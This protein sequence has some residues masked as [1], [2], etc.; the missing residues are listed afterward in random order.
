[1][2]LL[3]GADNEQLHKLAHELLPI[4]LKVRRA[5]SAGSSLNLSG[6]IDVDLDDKQIETLYSYLRKAHED[7]FDD[8]SK[9]LS[10]FTRKT[11]YRIF[12]NS[13]WK[14]HGRFYGGFWMSLPERHKTTENGELVITSLRYRDSIS[15]NHQITTELDYSSFHPKMIYDLEGLDLPGDPYEGIGDLDR[16]HG[17]TVF[18]IMINS[19]DM[20]KAQAAYMQD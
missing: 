10:F 7:D 13:S 11:L 20:E 1:M 6:L 5:A 15:I 16:D 19:K 8:H 9:Y 17:K 3:T 18:N 2:E 12:S 4:R 14:Q